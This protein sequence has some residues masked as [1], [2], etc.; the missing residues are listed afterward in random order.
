MEALSAKAGEG[1]AP[2]CCEVLCFGKSHDLFIS[3]RPCFVANAA[4]VEEGAMLSC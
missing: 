2:C 1:S 3:S 4:V